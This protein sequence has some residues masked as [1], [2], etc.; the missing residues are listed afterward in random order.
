MFSGYFREPDRTAAAF[1]NLWFHTGDRGWIDETGNL[2]FS[3]RMGDVIRRLGESVSSWQVE[4]VVL[5]HP[6]VQL[7]AAF[8]VPSE[9]NRGGG[10]GRSRSTRRL[11]PDGG[12]ASDWCAARLPRY[13]TPRFIEFVGSLPMTPTGKIEKF[14]LK[15]RG[16]SDATDDVHAG[17]DAGE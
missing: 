11:R 6:A 17:R 10:D 16:V 15:E 5:A 4:Q 3:D 2:W 13:A 9:L 8:G 1:R 14:K 12:R 7:A